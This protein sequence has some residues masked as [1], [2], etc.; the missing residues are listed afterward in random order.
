MMTSTKVRIAFVTDSTC[1]LA[2]EFIQ[3]HNIGVVPCYVNFGGKS[4]LDNNV[5]LNREDFYAQMPSIRPYATTSAPPPAAAEKIIKRAFA[6]ADHLIILTVP[7]NLSALYNSMRLGS[8]DLPQD[9]VT[10]ID[11]GTTTMALG[12]QVQVGVEVAAATGDVGATL[13]A[14]QSAR[15]NVNMYAALNTLE[16]LRASGRV[17][18]AAASLGALLQIKPIIDLKDGVV[19]S[20]ARVRTFNRAFDELVELTRAMAPLERLTIVHT[21][22][23]VGAQKLLERL[24]DIVPADH[25][26][27]SVTPTLGTHVGPGALGVVPLSQSWRT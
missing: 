26:T 25:R 6:E 24:S 1:D 20:I 21:S 10:L 27:I 15:E 4:Y 3:A 22:N 8:A 18:W 17:S 23:A 16:Y 5:D 14:I 13:N 2:P 19:H 12:Y 7:S 9:R 11:S